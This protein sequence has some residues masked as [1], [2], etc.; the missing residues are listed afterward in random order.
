MRFV[1]TG[2]IPSKKNSRRAIYVH[3]R[4]IM[5]ASKDHEAWHKAAALELR[6]QM[7]RKL[8][9]SGPNC[10]TIAL[11]PPNKVRGDLTNKAES[12]MDLLVD[13]GVLRDDNWDEVPEVNLIFAGVSRE[14]PR[15]EIKVE[16]IKNKK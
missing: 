10:V 4:T 8:I 7:P 9:L 14:N 1:I 3:G 5:I 16:R 15:A 6:V 11:Y 13:C 2:R 12:I